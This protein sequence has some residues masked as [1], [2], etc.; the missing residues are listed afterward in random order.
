MKEYVTEKSFNV[1]VGTEMIGRL[2]NVKIK[3]FDTNTCPSGTLLFDIEGTGIYEGKLLPGRYENNSVYAIKKDDLILNSATVKAV[4]VPS[5]FNKSNKMEALTV[6]ENDT[7]KA[8]KEVKKYLIAEAMKPIEKRL[9]NENR[10]ILNEDESRLDFIKML[11]LDNSGNQ[12]YVGVYTLYVS[13][14]T[15]S[16]NERAGIAF[17]EILFV[18]W[19]SGKIEKILYGEESSPAFS[20]GGVIDIDQNG[21]QEVIVQRSCGP[22]VEDDINGKRIEI[23]QHDSSGWISIYRSAL[24]C[25]QIN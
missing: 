4:A 22:Y 21:V 16:E 25:S 12:D 23:F 8:V 17:N 24:I 1:Y 13:N 7:T 2:S 18:L 14:K 20:L 3:L 19:G 10:I 15:V 6:T 11:D 5:L 9:I